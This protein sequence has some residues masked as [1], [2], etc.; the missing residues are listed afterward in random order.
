MWLMVAD[1][2]YFHLVQTLSASHTTIRLNLS[3]RAQFAVPE[4]PRNGLERIRDDSK[5]RYEGPLLF[6]PR[7]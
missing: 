3:N 2:T 5:S 6:L 4:D 1:G 7:C